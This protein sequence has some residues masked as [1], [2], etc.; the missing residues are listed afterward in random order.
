[1]K[2]A[3]GAAENKASAATSMA[4][5]P[6]PHQGKVKESETSDTDGS[7]RSPVPE[8]SSDEDEL[9][10][11]DDP[12][13]EA[14]SST[15]TSKLAL[16]AT[17]QLPGGSSTLQGER[18]AAPS[19]ESSA[20]PTPRAAV[21]RTPPNGKAEVDSEEAKRKEEK[22]AKER[23]RREAKKAKRAEARRRKEAEEAEIQ[24]QIMETLREEQQAKAAMDETERRQHEITV[25]QRYDWVVKLGETMVIP[26]EEQGFECAI[27]MEEVAIGQ[28]LRAFKCSHKAHKGCVEEWLTKEAKALQDAV[29]KGMKLDRQKAK[30]RFLSNLTC[31]LC[32]EALEC[33]DAYLAMVEAVVKPQAAP[34]AGTMGGEEAAAASSGP[35]PVE[36][37]ADVL[38]PSVPPAPMIAPGG[39]PTG[40]PL[41]PRTPAGFSTPAHSTAAAEATEATRV[42]SA[43]LM[44]VARP[45]PLDLAPVGE[46]SAGE[47]MS[48][49][50][51]TQAPTA[52]TAAAT[53]TST[54]VHGIET[55][56]YETIRRMAQ[57]PLLLEKLKADRLMYRLPDGTHI[58]DPRVLEMALGINL[59]PDRLVHITNV[60]FGAR[61]PADREYYVKLIR[62]ELQ[63]HYVF[64]S[65]VWHFASNISAADTRRGKS[66]CV[67]AY[68]AD[69]SAVSTVI[70][71]LH[72]Q[73]APWLAEEQ[74]GRA[75]CR[76][77]VH[78]AASA[79]L[80]QQQLE[81]HS[82][83]GGGIYT[84]R[85]PPPYRY[86][87]P[88]D[89][90]PMTAAGVF[91]LDRM[92]ASPVA[93]ASNGQV[94]SRSPLFMKFVETDGIKYRYDPA[95]AGMR[96]PGERF[97]A[98]SREFPDAAFPTSR[99]PTSGPM[100]T[101]CSSPTARSPRSPWKPSMKCSSA[102]STL[103]W[104]SGTRA[105][106][107]RYALGS[108]AAAAAGVGSR[109][110]FIPSVSRHPRQAFRVERRNP[111][112]P[113]APF[114]VPFSDG[115]LLTAHGEECRQD[116]S[117]SAPSHAPAGELEA[118]RA[119]AEELL[120]APP[121]QGGGEGAGGGDEDLRQA[122]LI[123]EQQQ[124]EHEAMLEGTVCCPICSFRAPSA[125]ELDA[126]FNAAHDPIAAGSQEVAD[127]G[128]SDM[129]GG[130]TKIPRP[131]AAEVL[132]S[133]P[134]L[135]PV[136]ELD[137]PSMSCADRMPDED[138]A[139]AR[140]RSE[141]MKSPPILDGPEQ[142]SIITY[143]ARL[144]KLKSD[145]LIPCTF[146]LIKRGDMKEDH[147]FNFTFMH[148]KLLHEELGYFDS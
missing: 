99:S 87:P 110:R 64:P 63:A 15:T 20:A 19:S 147:L 46:V 129:E 130:G 96:T 140:L 116:L 119:A 3:T 21:G 62:Q 124:R 137:H 71:R 103:L 17:S 23:E 136:H 111:A 120:P 115:M 6:A 133:P 14:S 8:V 41:G 78:R 108:S 106:I 56:S 50:R 40:I 5:K 52:P 94:L 9:H 54:P 77:Q 36:S 143:V 121:P 33:T 10:E 86:V 38:Y 113:A 35:L 12:R 117:L 32:R 53:L 44:G 104:S 66:G 82:L 31:P 127:G 144:R 47:W 125:Y 90:I 25:A 7:C 61:R 109:A 80:V 138:P 126:H 92:P 123:I 70:L 145:L 81:K 18:T 142:E 73:P 30:K 28:E 146:K 118:S 83:S 24:Q 85:P 65:F 34:R 139:V 55:Y 74:R 4:A 69:P 72:N 43:L 11:A 67:F 68:F 1:M 48:A 51:L 59:Q 105:A 122:L 26:C 141:V 79:D 148:V 45:P 27:C 22:K 114:T 98:D 97:T 76:L 100:A 132:P 58:M 16:Q 88:P 2:A 128:W 112:N 131:P 60:G 91:H 42:I 39:S 29:D 107:T 13:G 84:Y 93:P 102:T 101:L 89:A 37:A 135:L 134:A 95:G 57:S 75:D 49:P